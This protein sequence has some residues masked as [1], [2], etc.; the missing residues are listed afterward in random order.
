MEKGKNKQNETMSD[1]DEMPFGKYQGQPMLDIPAG[2]LHYLWT[3]GMQHDKQSPVAGYIR[4]N[5]AALKQENPD[6]IWS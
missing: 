3:N 2:Y 4:D 6:L 1:T 5:L